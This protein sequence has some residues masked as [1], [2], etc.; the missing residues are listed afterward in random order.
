VTHS[1]LPSTGLRP[2]NWFERGTG[3]PLLLLNGWTAS[4]L[5]WPRDFLSRLEEHRR[6]IR[7]DNRGTGFSRSAASPFTL[8]DLADDAHRILT[9]LSAT[10][11]TVVGMSMGGMVGQELALR[12]PADVQRLVLVATS[13]PAPAAIRADDSMTWHMFR[14]RHADETYPDYLM[15]LWTRAAA[16]GFASRR[17]DLMTELVAQLAVRPTTRYGAMAQ[18]RAAGCWRGP[19]RLAGIAAPVVVVHGREDRLRPVGNGMRI[20]RLIPGSR[21]LE[22]AGVGHLV[23]LEAMDEL[24]SVIE[25]G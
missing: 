1:A 22:L 11:A 4:S 5:V 14:R 23:P 7:I 24:V 10:P 13:P 25:E 21:Y 20:A 3:D 12:H 9:E 17:P 6:V 2:V 16:P 19:G 15:D 8:A 18:A